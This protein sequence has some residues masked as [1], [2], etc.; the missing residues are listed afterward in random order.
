MPASGITLYRAIASRAI[1]PLWMLEELGL[2]Y[3]SEIVD[4]RSAV[5]ARP[6]GLLA[7]NPS[8]RTPLLV[9]GDVAISESPA[10]C[11]YLADRYGYGTLAPKIEDPRRGP[12]LKWLVYAT[13]VLEPA[14][15]TQA[16]T[17]V[18]PKHGY[19]VGWPPIATVA[20]DLVHALE[21]RDHIL[22][23]AFTA[24]DVMLGAM[25]GISLFCELLPP[26]PVLVRYAQRVEARPAY[27]RAGALNWPPALFAPKP[28]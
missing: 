10:I 28:A 17:I 22:G 18:P 4:L 5:E 13:A 16:S 7:V 3:R 15:E 8:G 24:A 2:S 12:Y 11:I 14:R 1:V 26:E 9:D 20:R 23:D 21:G 6:A 25:I 27:V 19:G